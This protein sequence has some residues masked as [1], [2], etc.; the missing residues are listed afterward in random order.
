MVYNELLL[1][2]SWYEKCI[3]ILHRDKYRCQ[4]CGKLGFHN[5]TYYECQTAAELDSFLKGF[6]IKG[7]KPSVFIDEIKKFT[8]LCDFIIH[9]NEN[10]GTT[11]IK[12]V[13]GKFLYDL[14]ISRGTL[15]FS[16]FFLP[17]ASEYRIQDKK[18]K[19]SYL[20]IDK[21][22]I[23]I[24][25]YTDLQ[26][27]TGNFFIF[28]KSFFDSYIVRIEK[29]WPTGVCG[30][31]HGPVFWG[32]IIVSICYHECC[33][34]LEF[35]DKSHIDDEGN[36]LETPIAPKALN[37]H[38][39]YYVSGNNPWEYSNDAL[40]TLCQDC[41]CDEH[42]STRTPVYKDLYN[43]NVMAYAQFCDR[44]GGSGYLPQ[45]HHVEGGICFKCQGEGVIV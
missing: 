35:L 16:P 4:R 19:G 21:N 29:R 11:D 10:D 18:C 12:S 43:K 24:P 39:K 13:G 9:Q 15:G 30:D 27:S 31:E 42:K 1:E 5:N 37:V 32:S 36:Y 3:E 33:I 41:H 45:Y 20:P 44:C 38:H 26:Y 28:E 34:S 6:L 7:N 22:D 14:S 2:D 23:I 40:I 8:K 17:T 25:K